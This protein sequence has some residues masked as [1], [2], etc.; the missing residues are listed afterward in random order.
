[1]NGNN[2]RTTFEEKV[3]DGDDD[4]GTKK[5]YKNKN[6]GL[7]R[8]YSNDSWDMDLSL[9]D[10]EDSKRNYNKYSKYNPVIKGDDTFASPYSSLVQHNKQKNNQGNSTTANLNFI[11]P[12]SSFSSYYSSRSQK[13]LREEE[14]E[15]KIKQPNIEENTDVDTNKNEENKNLKSSKIKVEKEINKKETNKKE[16]NNNNAWEK[17]I[18]PENEYFEK[19]K[20]QKKKKKKKNK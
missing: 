11:I 7:E 10:D 6:K 13:K 16:N 1:M 19:L 8:T 20:N 5:K 2:L 4:N 17:E 9:S 15:I 12:T 18:E 3:D 14:K